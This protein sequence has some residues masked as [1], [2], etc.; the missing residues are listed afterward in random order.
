MISQLYDAK[1]ARYVIKLIT[2]D[3]FFYLAVFLHVA[4]GEV[5]LLWYHLCFAINFNTHGEKI[6]FFYNNFFFLIEPFIIALVL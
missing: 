2:G 5:F 4:T 3:R 1:L 6:F